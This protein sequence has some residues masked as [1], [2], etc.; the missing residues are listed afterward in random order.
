MR[1]LAFALLALLCACSPVAGRCDIEAT[2]AVT[3]SAAEESVS[4]RSIGGAC[5]KAVGVFVVLDAEDRPIWSWSTPLESAY[6][7]IFPPENREAMRDFIERWARPS[8]TKSSAAPEWT[9]LAPGQ[10]TLD[11]AT[12]EDIRARNLPMLCHSSGSARET[13]IFWEPAAGFAGHLY[14]R[15]VALAPE[16]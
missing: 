13:C 3:F 4:T 2:H 7:D 9:L 6:G 14:D 12:Y 1:H 16:E 10:S 8:V 5:N 15:D 11:A